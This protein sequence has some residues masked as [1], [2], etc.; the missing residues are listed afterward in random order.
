MKFLINIVSKLRLKK[1]TYF[2]A[3]FSK[4]NIYVIGYP[5][6]GNTWISFMIAYI[7]NGKLKNIDAKELALARIHLKK[8]LMGEN[9][10]LGS[11]KFE[12]VFK[13]H[14]TIKDLKIKK[15]DK[16]V[17]IS[18]DVRDVVNSYFWRMENNYNRNNY[19]FTTNKVL[20]SK[21][22]KITSFEFRRKILIRIFG[23]EWK[24][25]I[26]KHLNNN[27]IIFLRYE[28]FLDNPKRELSKLISIIDKTCN[29]SKLIDEAIYLFSKKNMK[30]KE[31]ELTPDRVGTSNNWKKYFTRKDT[32][33]FDK[34]YSNILSII[35][36]ESYKK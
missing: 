18:R 10:H 33:Y 15:E 26:E 20:F 13:S 34:K 25:H 30:N 1:A 6:S 9:E 14:C 28:N 12:Y 4:P 36:H 29:N 11:E 22:K 2:P 19:N 7:L 23:Y 16:V 35:N 27:Q 17:Y 5:I 21:L 32:I 31:M 24:N 8:Y 3:S